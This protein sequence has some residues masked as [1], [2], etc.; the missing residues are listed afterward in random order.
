MRTHYTVDCSWSEYGEWNSCSISCGA[1][2]QERT[3]KIETAAELGGNNCTGL[4]KETRPCKIKEC[5]GKIN[6][7]VYSLTY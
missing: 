7:N 2:V 1:G 3:R 6:N 4:E 5:P